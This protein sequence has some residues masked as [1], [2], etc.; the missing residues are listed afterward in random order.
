MATTALTIAPAMS[1]VSTSRRSGSPRPVPS[2][3]HPATAT[4]KAQPVGCWN[5]PTSDSAGAADHATDSPPTATKPMPHQAAHLWAA[6]W[7]G[8]R[9]RARATR[10]GRPAALRTM[11]TAVSGA[12]DE[13]ERFGR[14]ATVSRK[15]PP[16]TAQPVRDGAVGAGS[17]GG[18]R[19]SRRAAFG[20]A[21]SA[22]PTRVP[23]GG[24]ER[25]GVAPGARFSVT[26]P[27]F[28]PGADSER[29]PEVRAPRSVIGA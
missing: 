11:S 28:A 29:S 15:T 10:R 26:W 17:G 7:A 2:A 8:T 24:P 22:A 14:Y 21:V 4:M 1:A 18:G 3:Q 5:G 25:L 27:D 6:F 23:D 9:A 13:Y 12:I 16:A 19:P 20:A